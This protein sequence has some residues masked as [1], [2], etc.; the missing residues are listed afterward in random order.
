MTR[1]V[2]EST[3]RR[4]ARQQSAAVRCEDTFVEMSDGT[5]L[6]TDIFVPDEGTPCPALLVR[7]PYSRAAARAMVDP[8]A[9][10]RKSWAVVVQDCR[11]RFDSEGAFDPFHQEQQDGVDTIAW[12]AAQPWCDGRVATY[13]PSYL[14]I[15]QL[16][17]ALARPP[18]LKA[19]APLVTG[20][21]IRDEWM[22]PGGAFHLGLAAPWAAGLAL[23][24]PNAPEP[25]RAALLRDVQDW[26]A[27]F[28]SPDKQRTLERV[29]PAY[30]AWR[31]PA[32]DGY[33]EPLR[34]A[35]HYHEVDVP[36]F[37]VAGW[38]DVFAE[39]S[40]KT[41]AGLRRAAATERSRAG[42]RLVVGP[43]T[44][45]GIFQRGSAEFDFGP[46]ADG[47]A[48]NLVGEILGWLRDAVDGREVAGGARVYVMGGWGSGEWREL[49]D[50]PP[51]TEPDTW[52]LVSSRGANSLHGDG[53]LTREPPPA[54]GADRFLHD[55]DRPV[56]TRG[57]RILGPFYP[58]AG[59]VTQWDIEARDDVLV[60]TSDALD[61]DLV[62]VGPVTADITFQTSAASADIVVKLCDLYPDGRSYNVLDSIRRVT[63]KPG[64]PQS[65][66]V[67]VGSVAQR[68]RAGHCLRVQIAS[69]NFPRFDGNPA[70]G[71]ALQQVHWGGPEPSRI[72]LPILAE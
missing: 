5:L 48:A 3:R 22:Y 32:A 49:E 40:L 4:S 39:S 53:R 18:A 24:D 8:V 58:M 9:A 16:F 43:W 65:V 34:F 69:S 37:H 71:A 70:G 64:E 54:P 23:S 29:M 52:Y 27:F 46:L 19:M 41:F 13:G 31:D 1:N 61:H 10:A 28:R 68:F 51:R 12:I 26:D 33:W 59:P 38:Y 66:S 25:E 20:G 56:P 50:W 15:T 21:D 57:G 42:Q 14:G 30:A 2:P 47:V 11:G 72:H 7:C 44:H 45:V 6:A 60:Y 36:A 17:A 55:P 63:A 35:D 62:V 67:A